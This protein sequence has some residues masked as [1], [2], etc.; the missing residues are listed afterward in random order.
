MDTKPPKAA[1][2]EK[3]TKLNKEVLNI[4]RTTMRNHID[5]TQIADNKANVLLSLNALMLTFLAPFMLPYYEMISANKLYISIGIMVITSMITI[6]IA[7]QAL[8]PGKFNK[9]KGLLKKQ[10]IASPF[11]F[12]NFYAMSKTDFQE[13]LS[14]AMRT[15]EKITEY[16]TE[17]LYYLGLS[18]GRK[19]L[20]VRRA[21]SIFTIGFFTSV[22][23]ALLLIFIYGGTA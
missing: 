9:S 18:L 20:L 8:K 3:A 14:E 1:K 4:I 15:N 5:L 12:G 2:A 10:N 11:F 23:T 22:I 21:F 7:I 16:V 19:M 13:Y 6:Y 17:D